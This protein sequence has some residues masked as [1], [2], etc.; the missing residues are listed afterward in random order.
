MILNNFYDLLLGEKSKVQN[1]KMYAVI[2]ITRT[3]FIYIFLY[4]HKVSLE[5]YIEI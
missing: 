3:I 4:T 1:D 2:R 5:G